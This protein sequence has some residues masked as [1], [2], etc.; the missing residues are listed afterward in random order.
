MR[1]VHTLFDSFYP[2]I[3]FT[4]EVSGSESNFLD[5][6]ISIAQGKYKFHITRKETVTDTII[7]DRSSLCFFGHKIAALNSLIHR[8]VHVPM[9]PSNFDKGVNTIKNLSKSNNIHI[10]VERMTHK[11][12]IIKNFNLTTSVPRVTKVTK[13]EK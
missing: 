8:L 1:E 2:S 5:F 13:M 4:I 11:K 3:Q 9:D 6:T 10:D 7:I 12:I